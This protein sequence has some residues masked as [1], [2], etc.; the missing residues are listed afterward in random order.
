MAPANINIDTGAAI[1]EGLKL[2][3][4]ASRLSVSLALVV[5]TSFLG[6]G[7]VLWWNSETIITIVNAAYSVPHLKEAHHEC[8]V[9]VAELTAR[10][11]ANER[12]IAELRQHRVATQ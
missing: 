4:G 7:G 12:E 5:G 8:Q 11:S 9:K 6:C 1:K 10:V 3:K 2:F